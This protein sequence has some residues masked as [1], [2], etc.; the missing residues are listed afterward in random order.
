M[1]IQ[2]CRW[3]DFCVY[4]SSWWARQYVKVLVG[5]HNYIPWRGC[6]WDASIFKHPDRDTGH[7]KSATVIYKV[8][9][10]HALDLA[11]QIKGSLIANLKFVAH[12]DG[13]IK[14]RLYVLHEK[15]CY[16]SHASIVISSHLEEVP[17]FLMS[18]PSAMTW[19]NM[20]QPNQRE[21]QH[22]GDFFTNAPIFLS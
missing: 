4:V 17:V 10:Y 5:N 15:L 12:R 3:W 16:I 18:G 19:S 2:G 7:K 9:V 13:M 8:R 21:E 20:K 22:A 6:I 1:D 11:L 14:E